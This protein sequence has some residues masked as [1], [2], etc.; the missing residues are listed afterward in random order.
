M[1]LSLFCFVRWK[2]SARAQVVSISMTQM[3]LRWCSIAVSLSTVRTLTT[4][5]PSGATVRHIRVYNIATVA[6]L[7][8]RILNPS[9]TLPPLLASAHSSILQRRDHAKIS[10]IVLLMVSC[11]NLIHFILG[12]MMFDTSDRSIKW[13]MKYNRSIAIKFYLFC[14]RIL[15]R[16]RRTKRTLAD[17][18]PLIGKPC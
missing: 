8:T 4:V 6:V 14:C 11:T 1:F 18:R 16:Y 12:L 15:K 2:P 5:G 9:T 7:T 3:G 13:K 17:R 10:R